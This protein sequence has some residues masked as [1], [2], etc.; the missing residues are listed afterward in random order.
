MAKNKIA[1]VLL[2]LA[3]LNLSAQETRLHDIFEMNTSPSVINSH[4][5]QENWSR[6]QPIHRF[7]QLLSSEF[8]MRSMPDYDPKT[9]VCSYP[10][11]K[12]MA[13]GEFILF[14]M[15]TSH[16]TSIFYTISSDLRIWSEPV[17]LL[18]T[19]N[20]SSVSV[21]LAFCFVCFVFTFRVHI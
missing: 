6:L 10:R 19:Y 15:P 7:T 14:Y 3:G 8:L 13:N 12:K 2:M 5:G 21:R 20:L 1:I 4:A 16:G 17:M 11:V 9:H 18:E